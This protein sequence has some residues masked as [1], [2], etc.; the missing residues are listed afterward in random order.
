MVVVSNERDLGRLRPTTSV[1]LLD[2][3]TVPFDQ[4]DHPHGPTALRDPEYGCG[5]V[6]W[7][8]VLHISRPVSTAGRVSSTR[9]P[10]GSNPHTRAGLQRGDES[11]SRSNH[12]NIRACPSAATSSSTLS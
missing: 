11:E 12:S 6:L 10:S 8:P 3:L 1:P 9:P 5:R 7:I 4:A 2:L